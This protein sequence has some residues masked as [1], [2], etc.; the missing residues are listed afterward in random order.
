MEDFHARFELADRILGI[1][2]DDIAPLSREQMELSGAIL[3]TPQ[4]PENGP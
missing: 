2:E 1:D 4:L 3:N